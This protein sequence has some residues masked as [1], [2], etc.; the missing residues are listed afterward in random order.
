MGWEPEFIQQGG[1]VMYILL[2]CS[3]IGVAVALERG[4]ALRR[5]A[6]A[7]RRLL[8]AIGRLRGREDVEALAGTS[9]LDDTPLG[10]VARVVVENRR[11]PRAETEELMVVEGRR[12]ATALE[13]GLGLI[14]VVAVTAPLL[15][16]LGT[17]IGMVEIFGSFTEAQGNL[18]QGIKKALY[19]TVA[20]LSL[21]IPML[22]LHIFYSRRMERLAVLLEQASITLLNR[23]Y[24]RGGQEG[25]Q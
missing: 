14:E 5:N 17:V 7:P 18:P 11:R 24:S 25:G 6:V 21:G 12:A 13:R 19:T 9:L 20:G 16:L 10:R 23:L 3:V 15:G 8:E 22:T 1:S 2:G 4:F